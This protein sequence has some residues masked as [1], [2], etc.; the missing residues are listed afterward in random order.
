[1]REELER[2]ALSPDKQLLFG[3]AVPHHI[4]KFAEKSMEQASLHTFAK[5]LN[6]TG[7]KFL[8]ADR[9]TGDSLRSSTFA[10]TCHH[11]F[12]S[13]AMFFF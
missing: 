8:K 1:M 2:P 13:S 12:Q 10:F 7:T 6:L 11:T 9:D 3:M 5:C 4:L